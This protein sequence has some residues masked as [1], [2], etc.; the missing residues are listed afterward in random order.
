MLGFTENDVIEIIEYYQQQGMIQR[1]TRQL[2]GIISEWYGNYCFSEDD[3]MKLFNPDMVLYFVD[4]YLARKKIPKDLIDRNVRIDYGKLRHLILVDKGE[5]NRKGKAANGNFD[6]L[7]EIIQNGY[8][9]CEL[10][11]GFPLE[12][13][14]DTNN[15]T[16]LLYYFGLLT[17]QGP[18]KDKLRLIIPNETVKRL[19]YS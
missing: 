18:E 11:K 5:N 16:S 1:D 19:Y 10:V 14:T 9:S 17:I 13:L 7:K 8:T 12:Q 4:S 15:F 3:N 6:R 2:M